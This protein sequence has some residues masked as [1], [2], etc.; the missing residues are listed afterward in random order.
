[1]D[2]SIDAGV[3]CFRVYSKNGG[4]LNLLGVAR[5]AALFEREFHLEA[6]FKRAPTKMK[7]A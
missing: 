3:A 2:V 7:V 6:V 4:R 5:K 1:M